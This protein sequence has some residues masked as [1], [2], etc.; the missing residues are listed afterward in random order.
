MGDMASLKN[1]AGH[2]QN[3]LAIPPSPFPT[4]GFDFDSFRLVKAEESPLW[5]TIHSG[6]LE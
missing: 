5:K 2:A 3:D 1:F 4:Q 6:T